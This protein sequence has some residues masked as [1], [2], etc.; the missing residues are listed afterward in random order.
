MSNYDDPEM[1]ALLESA[2]ENGAEIER[3]RIIGVLTSAA[4]EQAGAGDI[5]G[6]QILAEAVKLIAY[7]SDVQ[8]EQEEE[9]YEPIFADDGPVLDELPPVREVPDEEVMANLVRQ[10]HRS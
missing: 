4:I 10:V 5:D 8:S 6:A 1:I 9:N 2:E 3:D 7:V